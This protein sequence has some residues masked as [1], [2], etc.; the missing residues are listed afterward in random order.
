MVFQAII[1]RHSC[2][3]GR[4]LD[5]S[6]SGVYSYERSQGAR[7]VCGDAGKFTEPV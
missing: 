2:Y 4:G 5:G 6:I 1:I 7:V 3:Q